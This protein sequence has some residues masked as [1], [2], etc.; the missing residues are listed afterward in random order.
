MNTKRSVLILLV[1]VLL[2]QMVFADVVINEVMYDFTGADSGHEWVEI[3][4][5]GAASVDLTDWKFYEASTNHGLTLQQ[6]SFDLGAG[7]YAII[8]DD[9]STFLTDNLGFSGNIYDSTTFSLSTSETIGLRDNLGATVDTDLTYSST[10]NLNGEGYTIGKIDPSGD[11]SAS[12]WE[13]GSLGGTPGV[14]NNAAPVFT[15]SDS[16]ETDEDESI[17]FTIIATDENGDDLTYSAESRPSWLA[18]NP[19]TGVLSGTPTNDDVG[20]Y[21]LVLSVT[22]G[23]NEP[24][25]QDFTLT[26]LNVNDAPVITRITSRQSRIVEGVEAVFDVVATDVDSSLSALSIDE[27]A[28][29]INGETFTS[30]G[31]DVPELSFSILP[32]EFTKVESLEIMIVINDGV[33][34]NDPANSD[35]TIF[36]GTVLPALQISNIRINGAVYDGSIPVNVSLGQTVTV[37][38]DYTNNFNQEIGHISRRAVNMP[39]FINHDKS[40]EGISCLLGT[41]DLLSGETR[42]EQFSF[43]V[44]ENYNSDFFYFNLEATSD[45]QWSSDGFLFESGSIDFQIVRE[46]HDLTILSTSASNGGELSC[47]RQGTITLTLYNSGENSIVPEILVYDGAASNF[48]RFNGRFDSG[49]L[50]G[51]FTTLEPIESNGYLEDPDDKLSLNLNSLSNGQH[52]LNIYIVSPYFPSNQFYL[53]DTAQVAVNI[54]NCLLS[55]TPV[56][57]SLATLVNSPKDFTLTLDEAGA[58]VEWSVKKDNEAFAVEKTITVTGTTDTFTFNKAI[59]GTYQVKAA[60]N[61]IETHLWTVTVTTGPVFNNQVVDI[62]SKTIQ[63]NNGKIVYDNAINFGTLANLD[64]LIII[65]D[66]LISVDSDST[67]GVLQ[68]PATITLNKAFANARILCSSTFNDLTLDA[69]DICTGITGTNINGKFTFYVNSFST[70]KVVEEVAPTFEVSDIAFTNVGKGQDATVSFTVKNLGTL[71]SINGIIITSTVDAK[72]NPRMV[73]AP[74]TLSPLQTATVQLTVAVPADETSSIH[75]IGNLTVSGSSVTTVQKTIS[76]DPKSFLTI[77]SVEVNGKSSGKLTIDEINDVEVKVSNDYSK[78]MEDITVTV[79]LLDVNGDDIEE[80]SDSFDLKDGDDDTVTIQLD[81]S[82]E[83]IDEKSYTMKI[84]VEGTAE[85]DSEHEDLET[86]EVDI[87]IEKHKVI[88]EKTTISSSTL[89]CDRQASLQAY[90]KNLGEEDED[91]VDIRV[92]NSALAINQEKRSISLDNF[93]DSD[94]DYRAS[95][96]FDLEDAKE[97]KYNILVEVFRDGDLDDSEEVSLTVEKCLIAS[98]TTQDYKVASDQLVKEAKKAL[99]ADVASIKPTVSTSFRD[100]T[101]YTALLLVLTFLT[102]V[103]VSL[104]LMLVFKKK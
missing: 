95:F 98:T 39:S 44:P 82:K 76:L 74:T 81:L 1:L 61:G 55:W 6:G 63:N 89:K 43:T 11:N 101:T 56:E 68:G 10:W 24:V 34:N 51:A 102:L 5:N 31:I 12:N 25:E 48:N 30:L 54:Q 87:D 27:D 97:G 100:T 32:I 33:D 104:G 36:E 88:L 79:K 90:V 45:A 23:I 91:D 3:Y 78:D 14:F 75:T 99:S 80:E 83:E 4:N 52:T 2:T 92:T 77:D 26:V 13:T 7:A 9:A 94:N 47:N 15:S 53:G 72:Y 69:T 8:A 60:I 19:S 62:A 40:C 73:N 41:W 67:T 103:A 17:V 96:A 59:A 29:T 65:T 18:L 28:S 64:N 85:D 71:S 86:T 35:E 66:S 49:T 84:I 50:L 21:D 16:H 57:S 37:Q 93:F 42:N 22:D 46:E 38:Y 70:Y 58:N 20:E